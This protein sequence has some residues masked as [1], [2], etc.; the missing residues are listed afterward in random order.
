MIATWK[1]APAPAPVPIGD[2]SRAALSEIGA[3]EVMWGWTARVV[4]M[5]EAALLLERHGFDSEVSPII[6]S[7]VE[8]AIALPWVLD[9]RGRAY[10]ALAR[11]RA[12]SMEIFKKVQTPGWPLTDEAAELLEKA[13]TIETDEDTRSEDL[14]LATSHRRAGTACSPHTRCG[15]WKPGRRTPR[16]KVR[17]STP[18]ST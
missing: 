9:H 8:H 5:A 2:G 12:H 14:N 13:I 11:Q 6:R 17:P 16:S 3:V 10:Q 18:T 15:S 7:M 1:T 4:R